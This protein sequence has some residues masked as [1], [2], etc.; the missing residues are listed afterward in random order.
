MS[1]PED[2]RN[3][4]F[5]QRAR[6]LLSESVTHVDS[7]IRSRLTQA[8]HAALE[9]ATAQ[10]SPWRRRAALPVGLATAAAIT[11]V[12]VLA[13]QQRGVQ[14]PVADMADVDLLA[15]GEAFELLEDDD[16]FYEWALA[17]EAGG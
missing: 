1:E 15:D 9:A 11:L 5:E 3:E 17:Q 14:V 2:R 8:R 7:H 4:A 16:S 10:H 13:W 6:E 12:A